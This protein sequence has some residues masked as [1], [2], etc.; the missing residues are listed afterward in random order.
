MSA[1]ACALT[2]ASSMLF[3][4]NSDDPAHAWIKETWRDKD[5][6]LPVVT[7]AMETASVGQKT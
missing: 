3:Q 6:R 5:P 7:L 1:K 2:Y 4:G